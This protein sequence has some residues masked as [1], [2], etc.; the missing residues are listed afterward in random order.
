MVLYLSEADVAQLLT[1]RDTIDALE[2]S[3]RHL[4]QGTATIQPRRRIRLKAGSFQTMMAADEAL[5]VFGFKAYGMAR[6][7]PRSLV[8]L[9]SAESGQLLAMVA[10]GAL[11]AVR[12]GAASG[13]ATRHMA[14]DDASVL[15]VIGTGGQAMTQIQAVCAVRPI[16]QVKVFSRD[17]QRREAF[18]RRVAEETDLSVQPADSAEECVRGSDVVTVITNAREPAL[19]GAWLDQG[20]HVNAAGGNSW[21]RRELD[22]EAVERSDIIAVDHLEQAKMECGDL[23]WAADQGALRWEQVQELAHL[24]AGTAQGR[25]DGQQITLFESQGVALEDIAAA[26]LAYRLAQDRGL[27]QALPF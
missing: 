7:E 1:V 22:Q 17:P 6:S 20:A 26:N 9:Y 10:A 27:G 5:G 3:F 14:R 16:R 2:E 21:V 19:Q 8:H 25:Q 15:G 13:L 11:G 4:G 24:V 23:I 18:A 12:T